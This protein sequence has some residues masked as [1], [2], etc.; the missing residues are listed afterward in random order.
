MTLFNF[1]PIYCLH[2]NYRSFY[3]NYMLIS[4]KI[5]NMIKHYLHVCMVMRCVG[6]VLLFATLQFVLR[7][8]TCRSSAEITK[9][10]I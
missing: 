6:T 8:G 7:D 9:V 1:Y 10:Q 2:V 5:F 3:I 4:D